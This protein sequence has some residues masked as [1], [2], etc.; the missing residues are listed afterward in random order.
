MT[1]HLHL[2]VT[3]IY[4]DVIQNKITKW[5]KLCSRF[6]L[7]VLIANSCKYYQLF[8]NAQYSSLL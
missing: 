4:W 3:T 7:E 8:L 5:L 2:K 6:N 1:L